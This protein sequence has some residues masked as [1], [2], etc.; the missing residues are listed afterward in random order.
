M[1][2]FGLASRAHLYF[3]T[4]L[5]FSIAVARKRTAAS[6]AGSTEA[7]A[8]ATIAAS[9]AFATRTPHSMAFGSFNV[10]QKAPLR[11]ATRAIGLVLAIPVSRR[12]SQLVLCG[13]T[14]RTLHRLLR[15]DGLSL[16]RSASQDLH[17]AEQQ[18][19]RCALW[20]SRRL[21]Q[22]VLLVHGCQWRR[23]VS[24][25][26][27]DA[28][29]AANRRHLQMVC[30]LRER[31]VPS[32]PF[33]SFRLNLTDPTRRH[34]RLHLLP[35][36]YHARSAALHRRLAAASSRRRLLLRRLIDMF[37]GCLRHRCHRL[38]RLR[39]PRFDA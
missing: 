1:Y 23:P 13:L 27:H 20:K 5:S 18:R 21:R 29:A 9:R 6:P 37:N 10:L 35:G 28:A 25:I 39:A 38:C 12:L 30:R 31:C 8:R 22:P 17:D 11:L 26:L 14:M 4:H 33:L 32:R 24:Q 19:A 15:R 16:E 36:G 7:G 3:G 2:P 34:L